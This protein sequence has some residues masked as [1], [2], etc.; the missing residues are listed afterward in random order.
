[1][2]P[3]LNPFSTQHFRDQRDIFQAQLRYLHSLG[4]SEGLQQIEEDWRRD[5]ESCMNGMIELDK[6]Y[7]KG[8]K[9]VSS[10]GETYALDNIYE[11]VELICDTRWETKAP[12]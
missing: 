8:K 6:A 10:S 12:E 11:A 2:F 1:M 4:T 3:T 7:R 9:L 5:W